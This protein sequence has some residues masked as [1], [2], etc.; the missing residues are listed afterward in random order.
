MR[1]LFLLYTI[2]IEDVT[3]FIK[4]RPRYINYFKLFQKKIWLQ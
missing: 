1:H 2:V 4:A 3:Y